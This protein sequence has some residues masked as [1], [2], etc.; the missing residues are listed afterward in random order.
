MDGTHV[1]L[2]TGDVWLAEDRDSKPDAEGRVGHR[3]GNI[4]DDP[5]TL[6]VVQLETPPTVDQACRF[7]RL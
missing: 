1:D 7:K 6:M 2:K 4:G 5:V 3:S